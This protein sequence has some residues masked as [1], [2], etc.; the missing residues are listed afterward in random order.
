MIE[1][2]ILV[3]KKRYGYDDD[4]HRLINL[5]QRNNVKIISNNAKYLPRRLLD[6]IIIG[7]NI[8]CPHF[9]NYNERSK[10]IW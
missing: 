8:S 7:I 6:I 10:I 2:T 3:M 5:L 4:K 1:V 9:K